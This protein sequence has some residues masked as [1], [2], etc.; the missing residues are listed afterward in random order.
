MAAIE[1]AA[2]VAQA[3]SEDAADSDF[4]EGLVAHAVVVVAALAAAVPARKPES[5]TT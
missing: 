2:E 1:P 3:A 5:A 4:R